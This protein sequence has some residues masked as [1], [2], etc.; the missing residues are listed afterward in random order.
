MSVKKTMVSEALINSK[1]AKNWS[2]VVVDNQAAK[3]LK[4]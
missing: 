2:L 3:T 1:K 4:Q